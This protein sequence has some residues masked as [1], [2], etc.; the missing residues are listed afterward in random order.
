[1]ISLLRLFSLRY[2][3]D[4]KLRT[5]LA[6]SAI[7]LGVALFVSSYVTNVSVVASIEQ[8]K[9]DLAGKAEWQVTAAVLSGSR[10]LCWRRSERSPT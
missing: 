5:L 10:R 7:S 4:H 2:F 6:F 8:T 9:R 1:M 3:R